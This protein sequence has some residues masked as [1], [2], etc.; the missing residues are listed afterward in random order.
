MALSAVSGVG[1]RCSECGECSE[2]GACCEPG[3]RLMRGIPVAREKFSESYAI[4]FVICYYCYCYCYMLLF[5]LLL[6]KVQAKRL[7]LHCARGLSS[8]FLI[9]R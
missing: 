4:L 9:L 1:G 3:E 8:I 7:T 6:N 2:R 5:F